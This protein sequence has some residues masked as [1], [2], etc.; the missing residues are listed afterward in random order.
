MKTITCKFKSNGED[1]KVT[2]VIN[3]NLYFSR[4]VV[5][6]GRHQIAVVR[7]TAIKHPVV[8]EVM[9]DTDE[10]AL[11]FGLLLGFVGQSLGREVEG[12]FLKPFVRVVGTSHQLCCH[13]LGIPHVIN[14]AHG[15][16]RLFQIAIEV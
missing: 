8:L 2:A 12:L 16:R 11:I 10:L 7:S 6:D 1:V 5:S 3:D 14:I 15:E 13:I 9:P 4:T